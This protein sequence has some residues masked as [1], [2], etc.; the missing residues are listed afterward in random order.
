MADPGSEIESLAARLRA[1]SR[2]ARL[3]MQVLA[4]KLAAALPANTIIEWERGLL[5]RRQVKAFEVRLAD[6]SYR[7]SGAGSSLQ[8]THSHAVRGVVLRTE[9]VEIGPWIDQLCGHLSRQAAVSGQARAAVERL[10]L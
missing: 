8:A 3:F 4:G 1:D 9:Q 7:L 10:L 6:H 5:K 2:D